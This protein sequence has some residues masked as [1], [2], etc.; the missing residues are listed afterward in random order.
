MPKISVIIPVLN[1]EKNLRRTVDALIEL[2]DEILVLD[3]GSTDHT[4]AIAIESGCRVENIK[5]NGFAKTRNQGAQLA[6]HDWL[7]F[8]DA[9]EVVSKELKQAILEEK[10]NLSGIY[11]FNRRNIYMERPIRF[12]GFYPD[13]KVRLWKKGTAEWTGGSVHEKVKLSAG[14]QINILAGDILHYSYNSIEEHRERARHYAMLAAAD[15]VQSGKTI[16]FW[17]PIVNSSWKFIRHFFL[18]LGFLDGSAGFWLSWYSAR[19][20]FLKYS[21]ARSG[22]GS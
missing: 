12:G 4:Q 5:W 2:A 22:R 15:L 8:L 7:F 19:E 21:I 17:K 16:P 14:M 3:S 1:E 11:T 6:I 13:R 9:D 18:R 10:K 20:V